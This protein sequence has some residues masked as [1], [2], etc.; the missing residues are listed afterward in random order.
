[1]I[2]VTG[3]QFGTG[4]PYADGITNGILTGWSALSGSNKFPAAAT[5]YNLG[6]NLFSNVLGADPTAAMA[7]N[8]SGDDLLWTD[9][10]VSDT[11][12]A[13]YTGSYRLYPNKGD[14]GNFSL[15]TANNFTLG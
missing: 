4:N 11:A 13:T 3:G 14:L 12:P 2:P 7:N 1:G 5:N 15:G 8:G 6:Q 10:I 9:I